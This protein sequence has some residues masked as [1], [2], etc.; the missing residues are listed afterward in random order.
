METT[1]TCELALSFVGHQCPK[2]DPTQPLD[3][4]CGC[5]YYWCLEHGQIGKKCDG[6]IHEAVCVVAVGED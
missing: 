3:L 4:G 5:E 2:D 6:R 1:T